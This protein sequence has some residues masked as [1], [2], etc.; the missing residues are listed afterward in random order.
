VPAVHLLG[1]WEIILGATALAPRGT[2]H[3][4]R[5]RSHRLSGTARPPGKPG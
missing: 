2:M 1:S 5:E 4:P 3:D